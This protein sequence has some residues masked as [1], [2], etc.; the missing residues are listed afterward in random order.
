MFYWIQILALV[1]TYREKLIFQMSDIPL[2]KAVE[3]V[4][5]GS[6]SAG[7]AA[8]EFKVPE[9]TLT[10][11][12]TKLGIVAA[13]VSIASRG[14]TKVSEN[15]NSAAA[16]NLVLKDGVAVN[17]ASR[18]ANVPRSTLRKAIK[19]LGKIKETLSLP[20][21]LESGATNV[22]TR[23]EN[24]ADTVV[25][26]VEDQRPK[27]VIKNVIVFGKNG[28]AKTVTREV[29]VHTRSAYSVPPPGIVHQPRVTIGSPVDTPSSLSPPDKVHQPRVTIGSPVNT[30][31]VF[32][33]SSED[34]EP[35]LQFA[36]VDGNDDALLVKSP[37]AVDEIFTP[38]PPPTNHEDVYNFIGSDDEVES[39]PITTPND[40]STTR[41]NTAGFASTIATE[42]TADEDDDDDELLLRP[43][44]LTVAEKL[45]NSID[46]QLV[47]YCPM[48]EF[49]TSGHKLNRHIQNKHW[50]QITK[51][52]KANIKKIS[53][54][55]ATESRKSYS[56]VPMRAV[57]KKV[58]P[59][60]DDRCFRGIVHD[61]TG[62][63]WNLP[64]VRDMPDPFAGLYKAER[65]DTNIISG[66][67]P[68]PEVPLNVPPMRF[69][70][71]PSRPVSNPT[72]SFP[73][74]TPNPQRRHSAASM[75]T[76]R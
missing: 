1:I 58:G 73:K 55:I 38:T 15:Q 23:F 33:D 12:L 45:L 9:T 37:L 65:G 14:Y 29:T 39:S 46:T 63:S 41:T 34:D 68:R 7:Q 64:G 8:R 70:Q 62:G 59:Y 47:K 40:A 25:V 35:E 16:L 71:G 54:Y 56:V 19:D 11:H 2:V 57:Q 13:V 44:R 49:M 27:T 3:A 74:A 42:N 76:G 24:V 61:A 22:V 6:L 17:L 18:K 4:K 32:T 5:A 51:P 26:T 50:E 31:I 66:P 28:R 60:W 72:P 53:D 43:K 75:T 69:V 36:A 20:A 10:A 21:T 30:H 67:E 52:R 48:C